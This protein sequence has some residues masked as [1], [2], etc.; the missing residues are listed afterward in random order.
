[1]GDAAYWPLLQAI[2]AGG[3]IVGRDNTP[4]DR[5][6]GMIHVQ[7]ESKIGSLEGLHVHF[8]IKIDHGELCELGAAS[9]LPHQL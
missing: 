1:M 9:H 2:K 4:T 5:D 8:H 7:S 6:S 3:R